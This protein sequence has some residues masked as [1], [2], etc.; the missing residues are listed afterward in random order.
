MINLE[1]IVSQEYLEN[2]KKSI[3][4]RITKYIPTKTTSVKPSEWAIAKRNMPIG[5]TDMP[6]QFSWNPTPYFKEIIDN[7]SEVSQIESIAI[8]KGAQIGYNVGLV[9]NL[10]GWIID[11][12]PGPSIF[13][14][15]DQAMAEANM[16]LRIDKMISSAGIQDKIFAQV[17]TFQHKK[18]GN[19]KSKKEFVGG[20]LMAIGPNSG[21]KLRNLSLRYGLFDEI[22][23]SFGEIKKEGDFLDIIERRFDAFEDTRK[24]I[25]GSTPTELESSR[26]WK[27]YQ[28]GDQ[29]KYHVPCKKCKELQVMTFFPDENGR[30]GLRYDKINEKFVRESVHYRCVFC[31]AVWK[32][33]DKNFFLDPKNGAKWIPTAKTQKENHVSYYLPSWYAGIGLRTWESI[34]EE[35]FLSE[36]NFSK[37]KV[38]YNT[39][40]GVPWENRKNAIPYEKVMLRKGGYRSGS[41]PENINPLL[42]TCGVDIQQDR[43]ELEVVAWL[44]NFE[45]YSIEY[46]VFTGDTSQIE[47][48]PYINLSEFLYTEYSGNPIDLCFIDSGFRT[49]IIY[50][51]VSQFAGGVH[52][53]MG[54]SV[55]SRKGKG[56]IFKS[57]IVPSYGIERIDLFT[58]ILKQEFYGY[59]QKSI[60][61]TGEIPRGFCH[62]P[63]DYTDKIFKMYLSENR[64]PVVTSGGTTVYRWKKIHERNE[65]LDCRIYAMGAVYYL[66]WNYA[67]SNNLEYIEWNDFWGYLESQKNT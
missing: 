67:S 2:C 19:T 15:G 25:Y 51:F 27:L 50:D 44:R 29:R 38:F 35:W 9:E 57:A 33:S 14:S 17:D 65:A 59:V 60:G 54:D 55:S 1:E 56:P 62:F 31:D 52:A 3:N 5:T 40:M 47:N 43:I 39:V 18:T 22:D 48:S 32:N 30:G 46:R 37:I 24:K 42:I 64:E 4:N 21:S 41:L 11:E 7:F 20:F 45:S 63:V 34:C 58:D 61:D 12:S 53:V 36:G 28:L 23:A 16:E 13:T 26:I 10:I 66:A 49:D 8:L 6:G